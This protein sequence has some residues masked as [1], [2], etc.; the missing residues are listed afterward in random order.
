[1]TCPDLNL[2]VGNMHDIKH[3]FFSLT[4]REVTASH[5]FS[6]DALPIY[7][8][9]SP[10]DY[11]GCLSCEAMQTLFAEADMLLFCVSVIIYLNGTP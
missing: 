2:I 8:T 5:F 11:S 9:S 7:R 10:R 4:A 6:I 3:R 1:M